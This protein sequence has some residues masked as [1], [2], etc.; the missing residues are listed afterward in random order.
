VAGRVPAAVVVGVA[1][2]G[3]GAQAL[4]VVAAPVAG[5]QALVVAGVQAPA[6]AVAGA[7][8]LVV[9]AEVGR[10]DL[11]EAPFVCCLGAAENRTSG[12]AWQKID[13]SAC[14]DARQTFN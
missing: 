2:A 12:V 8:A 3:V 11:D 10:A 13:P 6:A 7:Q 9:A 14:V 4:V 1:A 5:V